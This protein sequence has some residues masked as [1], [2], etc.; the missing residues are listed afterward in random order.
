[1]LT[2]VHAHTHTHSFVFTQRDP[3][4]GE[5]GKFFSLSLSLTKGVSEF[6]E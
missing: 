6:S 4:G 5:D 2:P 1:M 3:E